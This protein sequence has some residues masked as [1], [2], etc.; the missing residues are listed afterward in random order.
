MKIMMTGGTS[1]I[2][3][4]VVRRLVEE[5]HQIT[6]LARDPDKVPGL[7]LESRAISS[8]VRKMP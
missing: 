5:G 1:F 2:G 3:C 4:Y 6:I 7:Q 8:P